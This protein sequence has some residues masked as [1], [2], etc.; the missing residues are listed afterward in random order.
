M[1]C[2]FS[3]AL[4]GAPIWLAAITATDWARSQARPEWKYGAVSAMFRSCGTL[5]TYWSPTVSVTMKRPLSARGSR[6]APGR[7]RMPNGAYWVPPRFMP[8]WHSAQP[9]LMKS[10]RPCLLRRR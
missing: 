3:S 2:A 10:C 5:K 9:L 8:S 4:T 6:S 7:S 1:I